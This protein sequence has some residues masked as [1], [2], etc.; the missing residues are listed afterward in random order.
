MF[1]SVALAL[2][3]LA[4]SYPP[5]GASFV[6]DAGSVSLPGALLRSLAVQNPVD[7]VLVRADSLLLHAHR[8]REAL[9]SLEAA[10]R[11][12]VTPAYPLRWRAARAA[13]AASVLVEGRSEVRDSLLR[14][15][16]AHGEAAVTDRPDGVEG[17]YWRVAAKG[18]L[19]LHASARDAAALAQAIEAE[20][21]QLLAM[22]ETLAGAHNALGRLNMEVMVLPGWK[23][24]VAR[25]LAG[26]ALRRV[27]WD[28]AEHH[29]TRAVELEPGNAL[30]LR[31]LGALHYHRGR[32]RAARILLE[33]LLGWEDLA[34]WDR[35]FQQEARGLLE[36]IEG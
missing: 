11:D 10:L 2:L 31:D 22:D 16:I 7:T 21:T 8:P 23:R 29:L 12:D 6:S 15:A 33:R 26:D 27:G 24:S 25:L 28:T 35:V 9:S 19:S 36:R 20:A 13:T 3:L 1:S 4:P 32:E 5:V 18:R 30:Y 17:R 34:P 14:V